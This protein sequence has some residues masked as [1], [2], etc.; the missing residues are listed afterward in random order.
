M[1]E[2][3]LKEPLERIATALEEIADALWRHGNRDDN[4]VADS[5]HNI[6]ESLGNAGGMSV[7]DILNDGLLGADGEGLTDTL[8]VRLEQLQKT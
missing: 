4:S 6:A 2:P 3:K 8:S 1:D 7:S 5:L